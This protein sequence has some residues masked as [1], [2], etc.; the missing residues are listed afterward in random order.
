MKKHSLLAASVALALIGAVQ[1]A[2]AANVEVFGF[3]DQGVT[4]WHEDGNTGMKGPVG[5]SKAN[6]LDS[7]G[8][9]T[10]QGTSHSVE[11]GTGNVSTWGIKG[12]EKLSDNLEVIF[13][14][15]DGFLADDGTLYMNNVLFE[16]ESS[17]GFRSKIWGELKGGRMPAM[18]T[19]SGTTGLLNSRV[20]PFGAGWGNMTGGWKFTG[21]LASA[22]WNNMINYKTPVMHGAQLHFQHSFGG[23][24]DATEGTSDTDR[25]TAVGINWTGNRSYVAAVVDWIAAG[26]SASRLTDKDTWKATV[27]GHYK[28]DRF[29]LYGTAQ[30]LKNTKWIGGYSTKEYAPLQHAGD[31]TKGLDG[32][33]FSTGVD[34]P[35]AGGTVKVSAAWGFGENNNTSNQNKYDRVNLGLGYIYPLSRRT[36]IYAVGGYFWQ[37][38]DW[39]RMNKK[40][41]W[42]RVNMLGFHVGKV[43]AP[44]Q[45]IVHDTEYWLQQINRASVVA[46]VES[47]LLDRELARKIRSALDELR[48]EAAEPGAQHCDLYIQFEPKLLKLCGMEASRLHAGRSSQ[49][50]LATSNA[51]L[52]QERLMM[53]AGETARLCDALLETAKRESDAL[54]PAYTNGVQAQPTL[55]SHYLLA[56]VYVFSRDIERMVECVRRHDVCPMGSCVCNGT[57]WPLNSARMAELLG[58]ERTADNAFDAGQCRGNDL[59]LEASQI[60]ASVMLHIDAFLADFMTQ[61]S[62]TKPW[63][64]SVDPNGVYHSSAMPQKRNPGL[65]NDCRRDAG[66]VIGEAQGVLMRM[67]NLT[68]GMADVRDSWSMESLMTDAAV[69]VKTFAGIVKSLRVDRE[70]ALA[71][72]NAEWTCTQE[73]ADTLMREAGIDFRTGHGFAS[74]FVTYAREKGLTPANVKYEDF[75]GVWSEFA[76]GKDLPQSFPLSTGQLKQAVK[77]RHILENRK[78]P[79]SASPLMLEDQMKFA[80]QMVRAMKSRVD[81]FIQSRKEAEKTLESELQVL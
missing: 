73:I 68:L 70:R 21:T 2:S 55:Y 63:I 59:P 23:K 9:V 49:D 75:C 36:S 10:R 40:L 29:T 77:P 15:E 47:G 43:Q 41:L 78:T 1:Q 44:D 50:I 65:I 19:G 17:V 72:L 56:Q 38:A 39:P 53:L 4:Y 62:Q 60:A 24:N 5:Q 48:R 14:L 32:W 61:Y 54:V 81:F 51:A 57:G 12:S 22:R 11:E 37:D 20:N 31:L 16:R 34:V 25:W 67:Q 71:E 52:N 3:L 79:G 27:G 64:H 46:N 66:L 8:Y 13:H 45:S 30:Y 28:F 7:A 33:A 42:S 80:S 76:A 69:V 58:F 18:S 35:A 26:N 74:R 6:V